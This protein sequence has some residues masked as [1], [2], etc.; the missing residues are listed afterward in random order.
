MLAVSAPVP[1]PDRQTD[2]VK[3]DTDTNAQSQATDRKRS[4]AQLADV[5]DLAS[6]RHADAVKRPQ[7]SGRRP[8]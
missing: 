8:R 4:S 1:L 3:N 7:R 2:D 6:D 5:E